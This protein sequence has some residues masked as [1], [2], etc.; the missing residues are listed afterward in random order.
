MVYDMI[1]R[2]TMIM[3]A[4]LNVS[5]LLV[6]FSIFY[7]WTGFLC[8]S[9]FHSKMSALHDLFSH[10]LEDLSRQRLSIVVRYICF[11]HKQMS[12]MYVQRENILCLDTAS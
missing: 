8:Y 7:G 4:L 2:A 11:D 12:P 9:T 1:K 5:G 10:L 3:L 6:T